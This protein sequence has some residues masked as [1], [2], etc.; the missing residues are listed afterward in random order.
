MAAN[1]Y[2][3]PIKQALQFFSRTCSV[4]TEEDS[5]YRPDPGQFSVAQHVAHVAHTIDWFVEGA[6]RPEGFDMDFGAHQAQ[7]RGYESL[8]D[9]FLFLAQ[10][11]DRASEALETKTPEE[12]LAPLPAGPIMGGEPRAAI[13]GAIM[14]HTAHHRGSLAVYARLLGYA[15]PMPY[16][17]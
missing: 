15:P 16:G 14:E 3:A 8:K 9:A 5:G 12:M 2:A 10:A 17:E 13:V 1:A 7:V 4:F 6:F 11:V